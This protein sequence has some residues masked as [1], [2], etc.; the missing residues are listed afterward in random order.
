MSSYSRSSVGL[1][2]APQCY[3]YYFFFQIKYKI[4]NNYLRANSARPPC[5]YIFIIY[6]YY[7]WVYIGMYNYR[8]RP[9]RY[10]HICSAGF[11]ISNGF[12]F[13]ESPRAHCVRTHSHRHTQSR[14]RSLARVRYG[15]SSRRIG[16]TAHNIKKK[17]IIMIIVYARV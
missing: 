8:A 16:N 6:T 9:V 7:T 3:R 4:F 17:Y 12:E 5:R 1:V 15:N 13:K 2:G 14:A 11:S 10:T